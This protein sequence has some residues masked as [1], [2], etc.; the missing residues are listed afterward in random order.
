MVI[1]LKDKII[2]KLKIFRSKYLA[3]LGGDNTAEGKGLIEPD[4]IV[5]TREFSSIIFTTS[6]W[7]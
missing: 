4:R 2:I 6:N 1:L 5:E 3:A 7:W